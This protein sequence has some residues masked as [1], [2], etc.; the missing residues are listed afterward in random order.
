MKSWIVG[1]RSCLVLLII[2]LAGT[3]TL[4]AQP[5]DRAVVEGILQEALKAWHA[6]GIAVAIVHDDKRSAL[7][8]AC[9]NSAATPR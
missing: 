3:P 2:A 4:A 5:A 6:P 7:R 9:A 1:V 8:K